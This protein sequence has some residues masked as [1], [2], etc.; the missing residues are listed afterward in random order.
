MENTIIGHITYDMLIAFCFGIASLFL[1][2]W[3]RKKE[4]NGYTIKRYMVLSVP[5]IL[6][7][8]IASLMV[9]WVLHEI[10][11]VIISNFM[12]SLN[13][14]G[15]YHA[16]LACLTGMFGSVL[17][18]RVL[19]LGRKRLNTKDQNIKHVHDEHCEH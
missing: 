12:P 6:F 8:I 5:N 4:S 9:L 14:S 3:K 16:V 17:V 13:G 11:E 1:Y 2:A 10:S 18:A 7:H 19:E 15:T